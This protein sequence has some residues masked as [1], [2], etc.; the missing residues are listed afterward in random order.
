M[1]GRKRQAA[2]RWIGAGWLVL[3]LTPGTVLGGSATDTETWVHVGTDRFYLAGALSR[4]QGVAYAAD[5][6]SLVFSWQY[7]LQRT[8]LDYQVLRVDPMAIPPEILATG[9]RHI[10]GI[11]WYG[12][13]VYAPIEDS[14]SYLYPYVALFDAR[15]LRYTGI[16]F[17]LPWEL[18]TEGVPWVA[19]DAD[20]G[21]VY[22]SEW[23][24][25]EQIN[26]YDLHDLSYQ[27]S[28]PLSPA[29]G[30][31]QGAKVHDGALYAASDNDTK[32][33]YR[34]DLE[35]GEV[36]E[37]F[38]ILD[39]PGV[40]AADPFLETEDLVFYDAPDG[41]MLHVILIQSVFPTPDAPD[42]SLVFMPSSSLYHFARVDETTPGEMD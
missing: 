4:S 28:L 8:T 7:G 16:R 29:I 39:L 10:G 33:V 30:R 25:V 35:T 26:A 22:A 15:T 41:S 3:A 23:N 32:S 9:G 13:L 17:L 5:T 19:V 2:S 12:G 6:D 27:W 38:R 31:I 42:R 20:R 36:T 40:Y 11:D 24:P 1:T 37:L 21:V 34:I 18:Q 14:D